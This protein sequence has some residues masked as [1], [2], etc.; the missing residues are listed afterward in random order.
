MYVFVF[1]SH[2][3]LNW[4]ICFSPTSRLPPKSVGVQSL[5][6][7]LFFVIKKAILFRDFLQHYWILNN[8]YF[9]TAGKVKPPHY[10]FMTFNKY[11]NF[12]V[13]HYIT[14]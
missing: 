12:A 9:P 7:V 11:V 2:D 1:F 13:S 10:F 6:H 8:L 4:F 5:S 3:F 14:Q